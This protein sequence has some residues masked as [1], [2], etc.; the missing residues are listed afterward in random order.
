MERTYETENLIIYWK[1]DICQ[2]AGECT[3]GLPQVFDVNKRPWVQ[4]ENATDEEITRVIDRCPSG[5]LSYKY[6]TEKTEA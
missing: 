1:P 3:R 4:P 2:H 6:K 5:A